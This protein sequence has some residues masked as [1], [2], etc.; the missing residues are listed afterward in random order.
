MLWEDASLWASPFLSFL[1]DQSKH[2]TVTL[3]LFSSLTVNLF[4]YLF[5]DRESLTTT[6]SPQFLV[7]FCIMRCEKERG[8]ALRSQN[9]P[10][11]TRRE[12]ELF[13]ASSGFRAKYIRTKKNTQDWP[14]NS[15]SKVW[16]TTTLLL[17]ERAL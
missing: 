14:M 7:F 8:G 9:T 4:S 15:R 12:F 13:C 5:S 6:L 3:N 16:V 10:S 17:L 1:S 11:P 2:N